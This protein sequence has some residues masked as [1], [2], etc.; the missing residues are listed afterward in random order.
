MWEYLRRM[1]EDA[2]G[3]CC[4]GEVGGDSSAGGQVAGEGERTGHREQ[5]V[6]SPGPVQSGGAGGNMARWRRREK[7]ACCERAHEH[8]NPLYSAQASVDLERMSL[9]SSDGCNGDGKG[10][11]MGAVN[12]I[13]P[14]VLSKISGKVE[15]QLE[16]EGVQQQACEA[17][18]PP[19]P[20]SLGLSAP[21]S[22]SSTSLSPLLPPAASL[23]PVLLPELYLRWCCPSAAL[24]TP[25]PLPC[26]DERVVQ[27]ASPAPAA[28]TGPYAGTQA[29]AAAGAGE[30]KQQCHGAC[31]SAGKAV[32][33]R[34][35]E[36]GHAS[37]G[38]RNKAT[39]APR[40]VGAAGCTCSPTAS[41]GASLRTSIPPAP[42]AA[43]SLPV[44]SLGLPRGEPL[45][46]DS[47][48]MEI[49]RLRHSVA[50]LQ[51]VG[52]SVVH[53]GTGLAL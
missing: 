44:P 38:T 14:A 42:P 2:D 22:P 24:P 5:G 26:S 10:H 28:V 37:Q 7:P 18:S 48:A 40:A 41:R 46:R 43:L 8:Y 1:R 36:G 39:A 33:R 17:T 3:W 45:H 32:A 13:A 25:T 51:Q 9:P 15:G 34:S 50:V 30:G 16:C 4:P 29:R 52:H 35:S 20:A 19:T 6:Q 11:G 23:A 49:R 53:G 31:R 21:P 47:V 12:S 27:A